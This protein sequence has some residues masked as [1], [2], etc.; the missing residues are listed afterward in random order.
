MALMTTHGYYYYPPQNRALRV[1][2]TRLGQVREIADLLR[3]L[4]AAYN[5]IYVFDSLVSTV[6]G[7]EVGYRSRGDASTFKLVGRT[8]VASFILPQDQL[9]LTKV[10]FQSPGFWEF[11][12]SLNPLEVMRKWA[13]DRHDRKKDQDFRNAL[14]AEKMRLENEKLKI[15]VVREKVDLLRQAGVPDDKIRTA[16][17]Q[18]LVEPLGRLERHQ[19]ADLIGGAEMTTLDSRQEDT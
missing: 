15:E 13:Q 6:K 3:D 9:R 12:G 11:A 5:G 1:H 14:T 18:Y 17:T 4:E 2:G 19:D 16:L 7:D 10:E 8:R